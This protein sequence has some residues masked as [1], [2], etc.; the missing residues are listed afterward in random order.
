MKTNAIVSAFLGAF[1]VGGV[2]FLGGPGGCG[3]GGSTRASTEGTASVASLSSVPS[4]DLSDYDTS[5]S[6]SASLSALT[7][8]KSAVVRSGPKHFGEEMRAEGKPSRAGCESNAQKDEIIRMSQQAQLDRCYPEAMEAAGLITI[9]EGSYALYHVVP[10]AEEEEGMEESFCEEIPEEFEDE[11]AACEGGGAGHPT[12]IKIRIGRFANELRID[13]CEGESGSESLVDEAT[14]SADGSVYTASV[15]RKGNWLGRAEGSS[16]A[17]TVDLGT[18]GTVTDGLVSLGDGSASATANIDGGF[19]SGL[20]QF[21]AAGGSNTIGGAFAGE[22]VDPFTDVTT[23]FTGKAYAAFGGPTATGCAKFSFTGAPPPMRVQDMIPFG[24]DQAALSGFLQTLGVELGISITT[25]NYL[26]LNLCPNPDFDPEA[27]SNTVKPMVAAASDGTCPTI[28]N[29]GIECFAITVGTTEGDFGE[30]EVSQTFTTI[31]DSASPFFESVNAFDLS[32]LDPT[33]SAIAYSRNWDCT[34]DFSPLNFA[35]FTPAQMEILE[36]RLQRCFAL[37]EEAFGREGMGGYNC[38]QQ[39]QMNGVN[40]LANEGPPN[41]GSFGGEYQST[42]GGTCTANSG[43]P[44]RLFADPL[45]TTTNRYCFPN[46]GNC[47][48]FSV[49]NNAATGT[50]LVLSAGGN[51]ITITAIN[52]VVGT[53]TKATVTYRPA[54]GPTCTQVYDVSQP[55]FDRP[56]EFGEGGGGG[57]GEGAGGVP[58]VCID[59]FGDDVTQEE[60]ETL[61]S[62]RGV[63]CRA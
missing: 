62:Q 35:N 43:V 53:P 12:S 14:Y 2:A 40:D 32:T 17:M 10:P 36:A 33:I 27:F 46:D 1:M 22:F 4:V 52:Y 56:P 24:I 5:T 57:P 25:A 42:T 28:T 58:Q 61:C 51:S 50:P 16:F 8:A 54:T 23:R 39:E 9:P 41:F 3:G 18:T 55:T 63:D 15:V 47:A 44:E 21:T 13:M 49:V 38:H 59:T 26:S 48:E 31:A 20:M 11:R 7:T 30:E 29:T 6:A 37:E 45:D 60:C 19:G 34:G